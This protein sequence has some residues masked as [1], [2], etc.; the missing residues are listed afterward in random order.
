VQYK[1]LNYGLSFLHENIKMVVFHIS[2]KIFYVKIRYYSLP[3][4]LASF[5]PKSLIRF[6]ARNI[7]KYCQ[8]LIKH[9]IGI[10]KASTLMKDIV[11]LPKKFHHWY[12]TFPLS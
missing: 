11:V 3:V 7:Y 5:F 12:I 9:N 2:H 1:T 4:I 8:F 10:S 6:K